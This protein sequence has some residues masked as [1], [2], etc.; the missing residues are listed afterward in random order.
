MAK[1]KNAPAGPA[2]Q[3][4]I[5]CLVL[6]NYGMSPYLRGGAERHGEP[7]GEFD[8]YNN[9][10]WVPLPVIEPKDDGDNSYSYNDMTGYVG[11]D[12]VRNKMKS[13]WRPGLSRF[14]SNADKKNADAERVFLSKNHP[15]RFFGQAVLDWARTHPTDPDV[16]EMLYRVV[17]LPKWTEV[18]PVGSE[19]SK[20]A[21][22]ALH[23]AYPGN[24]WTKKAVCYY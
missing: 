18:T 4:A 21:Y 6:R 19:F 20:K 24:Q 23:K 7:I 1:I 5:S 15:S 13:Y 8:Y 10:F 9:N 22:F 11:D 2:R 16:P 12:E 17:K 14:L 3:F